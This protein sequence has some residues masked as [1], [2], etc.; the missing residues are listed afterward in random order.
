MN[1]KSL[2]RPSSV[3]KRVSTSNRRNIVARIMALLSKD[4]R[5]TQGLNGKHK[6]R[7]FAELAMLLSAG[8]DLQT[9][10]V[11]AIQ[12]SEKNRRLFPIYTQILEL[13]SS[14]KGLAEAMI[15]T[16]Q[17]NNFDS[18]SVMIGENTGQ[19]AEVF[20]K[21]QEYYLKKNSQ[22]RKVV[23]ALS[24]PIIVLITTLCAIT[25]MLK[26][27]VPMFA[28]TLLRFGGE[29]P[30]LTRF[31]IA[32]SSNFG[33]VLLVFGLIVSVAVVLYLSRR[34]DPVFRKAV[35]EAA[36][37]LPFL[38]KMLHTVY[39]TQFSQAMDLLLSSKVNIVDSIGLTQ[40]MIRFFPLQQ[41][42]LNIQEEI[43]RGSFFHKSMARETFFD[44]S[45]ITMIKIGEEV[46]QLDQIF[47]QLSRQYESKLEYQSGILLTILEPV[48]ILLLAL[49]VGVI[50]VAMYLPMFKMGTVIH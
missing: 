28:D 25:F 37:R 3:S 4:L 38:G 11:L 12:G 21:L 34:H 36:L 15:E 32:V 49:I 43:I 24:Y 29:L 50:L 5:L 42:L 17:F 2:Q 14:G 18:Y 1:I 16:R 31:I 44:Q 48:M 33:W 9:V 8:V 13:V 46:N 41:S 7:F 10:L 40:K 47:K 30:R 19:L 26:F 39:L 23:S 35:S 27:V 6:E 22:S 20:Q 45:M